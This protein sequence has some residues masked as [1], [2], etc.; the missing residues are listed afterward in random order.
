MKLNY[1]EF[2]KKENPCILV[3]HGFLGSNRNW[4]TINKLLEDRYHV[5]GLDM[6]NH[7]DSEHSASNSYTDMANDIKDFIKNE[8][9]ETPILLGHSMGGKVA[10]KFSCLYPELLSK[11]IVVDIAP[12]NYSPHRKELEAMDKVNLKALTSKQE[13]ENI[14]SETITDFGLRKFLMTNLVV[15]PEKEFKWRVNIPGLKNNLDLL[16]ANPL[17]Q[18]EIFHGPTFFIAGGQS[19]YLKEADH[20]IIF[21]HFPNAKISTIASS[22]HNPHFTAREAFMETLNEILS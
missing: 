1:Q 8:G 18:N 19:S 11:V 7:G 9:C 10:M 12:K 5:Y 17:T 13:A 15:T 22:D 20:K 3:L 4:S 2:G 16:V 14:L 6:R 21:Q